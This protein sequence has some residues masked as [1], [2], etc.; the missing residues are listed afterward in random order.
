MPRIKITELRQTTQSPPKIPNNTFKG[1]LHESVGINNGKALLDRRN[2]IAENE[3]FPDQSSQQRSNP[4]KRK[5]N[6]LDRIP[7]E[8]ES[9]TEALHTG[10]G[11][12]PTD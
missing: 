7:D 9:P 11:K 2:E 12:Q 1:K 6:R 8:P 10:F 4:F 3:D 5:V